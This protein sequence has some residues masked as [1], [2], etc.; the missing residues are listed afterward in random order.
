MDQE[1]GCPSMFDAAEEF[2][3]HECCQTWS[4]YPLC[5]HPV[6]ATAPPTAPNFPLQLESFE[7]DDEYAQLLEYLNGESSAEDVNQQH[8]GQQEQPQP[9]H[10]I[11][12][13]WD[14]TPTT[15]LQPSTSYSTNSSIA[16]ADGLGLV[17]RQ[18]SFTD[19]GRHNLITQTVSQQ[20]ST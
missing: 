3:F 17:Q 16:C 8:G 15:V 14:V 2:Y 11:W 20:V 7:W 13:P 18:C 10:R 6:Y 1:N 4:Q 5:L 9:P 12:R 19:N